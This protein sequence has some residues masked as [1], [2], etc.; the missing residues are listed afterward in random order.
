[1]KTNGD[2]TCVQVQESMPWSIDMKRKKPTLFYVAGI[3]CTIFYF[4][5]ITGMAATDCQNAQAAAAANLI[6][7]PASKGLYGGV[8][9][10]DINKRGTKGQ[11]PDTKSSFLAQYNTALGKNGCGLKFTAQSMFPAWESLANGLRSTQCADNQCKRSI[12][13]RLSAIDVT[14]GR[15]VAFRL[16]KQCGDAKLKGRSNFSALLKSYAKIVDK[17][18]VKRRQDNIQ[19]VADSICRDIIFSSNDAR[20]AILEAPLPSSIIGLEQIA[21]GVNAQ[22]SIP[23]ETDPGDL[24][25]KNVNAITALWNGVPVDGKTVDQQQLKNGV[26]LNIPRNIIVE[27]GGDNERREIKLQLQQD[28]NVVLPKSVSVLVD[29]VPPQPPADVVG[30]P[31][32]IAVSAN[33]TLST[34]NPSRQKIMDNLT[35]LN[36]SVRL[37]DGFRSGEA[38]KLTI[39]WNGLN[40]FDTPISLGNAG[41]GSEIPISIPATFIEKAG[42]GAFTMEVR[43]LD[44]VNNKSASS[45]R[46]VTVESAIPV[47]TALAVTSHSCNGRTVINAAGGRISVKVPGS[48][49]HGGDRL[50]LMYGGIEVAE[51]GLTQ[52]GADPVEV[53]FDFVKNGESL[54]KLGAVNSSASSQSGISAAIRRGQTLGDAISAQVFIDTVIPNPATITLSTTPLVPGQPYQFTVK[55]ADSGDVPTIKWKGRQVDAAG[56][57]QDGLNFVVTL[58]AAETAF[59]P[60]SPEGIEVISTDWACN[61]S[62]PAIAAPTR[63][64][65]APTLVSVETASCSGTPVVNSSVVSDGVDVTLAVSNQVQTGANIRIYWGNQSV[66]G[67]LG[68]GGKLTVPKATVT[69]AGEGPIKVSAT[70]L[71]KGSE[72]PPSNN[73]Q[74]AVDFTAPKPLID[75]SL[76]PTAPHRKGLIDVRTNTTWGVSPSSVFAIQANGYPYA[77][78]D[79]FMVTMQLDENINKGQKLDVQWDGEL[80]PIVQFNIPNDLSKGTT[81]GTRIGLNLSS[82]TYKSLPL[83]CGESFVAEP[84]KR[85]CV[86]FR[87]VR[88]CFGEGGKC[89]LYYWGT[90][91]TVVARVIDLSCNAGD[92]RG[93]QTHV[94]RVG[95]YHDIPYQNDTLN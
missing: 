92:W 20:V 84:N 21:G 56:V 85:K 38:E 73:I 6:Y 30:F 29:V 2:S 88:S 34:F 91:I 18:D 45:S 54:G 75:L 3:L 33:G 86:E 77:S 58:S 51:K 83:L 17:T 40:V 74:V 36:F 24:L 81:V 52:S 62:T 32:V 39:Q 43:L 70:V 37:R 57:V 25:L 76:T 26:V 28:S 53:F 23:A 10:A 65:N 27:A 67:I 46:I 89:Y 35:A 69:A 16:V 41:S 11:G 42:N 59:A 15:E 5:P 71:S 93:F 48:Q 55:M 82:N 14:I 19:A 31:A 60:D 94:K 44:E 49:L 22:V 9:G 95:Y 66:D 87:E 90:P 80:N 4:L 13:N 79:P 78:A 68:A 12:L 63:Q 47:P 50:D 72:S 64:A 8:L 1:M 61:V 7:S